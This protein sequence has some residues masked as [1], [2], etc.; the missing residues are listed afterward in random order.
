MGNWAERTAIKFRQQATKERQTEE[1]EL[2][3]HSKT[4]A[5]A[6]KTWKRLTKHIASEI[7]DFNRLMQREFLQLLPREDVIE[8]HGPE[9]W[10]IVS[11]DLRMPEISFEYKGPMIGSETR[12]EGEFKFR[13]SGND[14]LIVGEFEESLT[15]EAAT[16]KLL[17]PLIPL[18]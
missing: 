3:R 9:L 16:G 7:K 11:F 12:E 18:D 15:I 13:L 4:Q 5:G 6:E 8:I 1:L 10:L 17:D 14:V 2:Q